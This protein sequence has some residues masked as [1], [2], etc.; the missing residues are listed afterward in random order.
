MSDMLSNSQL[1]LL[2]DILDTLIPADNNMPGAGSIATN[3][4]ET[5]SKKSAAT[6]RTILDMLATTDAVPQ[7]IFL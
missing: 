6:K 5:M 3:F 2:K 4:F 1:S 7:Q